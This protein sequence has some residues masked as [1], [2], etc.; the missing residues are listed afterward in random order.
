[1][2]RQFLKLAYR[3]SRS[4]A[5]KQ[6]INGNFFFDLLVYRVLDIDIFNGTLVHEFAGIEHRIVFGNDQ[7]PKI[8]F[9]FV[10][11]NAVF[12]GVLQMFADAAFGMIE[13]GGNRG[14]GRHRMT[15]D[16]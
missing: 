2:L 16:Q 8:K 11:D 6:C 12:P 13:I 10:I 5:G 7:S 14:N 15:S 4:I 9:R 3:D 1:M